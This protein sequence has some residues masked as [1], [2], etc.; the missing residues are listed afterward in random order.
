M[1]PAATNTPS[2]PCSSHSLSEQRK[3]PRSPNRDRQDQAAPLRKNK[4]T[5][6]LI[7]SFRHPSMS[8]FKGVTRGST[9]SFYPHAGGH[10]PPSSKSALFC[11]QRYSPNEHL[12]HHP[13]TP[14]LLRQVAGIGRFSAVWRGRERNLL[15]NQGFWTKHFESDKMLS[16]M[17]RQGSP[18]CQ[19]RPHMMS[20]GLLKLL[21]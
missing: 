14:K 19:S 12:L 18:S 11:E 21:A 16:P 17:K 2:P 6:P 20:C 4:L 15:Q 5:K 13:P 8:S 3:E 9:I 10:Q 7:P 1:P